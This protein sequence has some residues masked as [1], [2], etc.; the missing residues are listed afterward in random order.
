M[1]SL[2]TPE[3]EDGSLLPCSLCQTR[4]A[5][6]G[7]GSGKGPLDGRLGAFPWLP[8]V[9]PRSSAGTSPGRTCR[10]SLHPHPLGPTVCQKLPGFGVITVAVTVVHTDQARVVCQHLC[11]V[12]STHD[13]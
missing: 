4:A 7:R 6:M 5:C 3:K 11:Q 10:W 1:L 8:C 13:L 12:L 2:K 9:Q